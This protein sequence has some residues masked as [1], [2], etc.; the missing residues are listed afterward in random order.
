MWLELELEQVTLPVI[1]QWSSCTREHP[2]FKGAK[3]GTAQVSIGLLI[4]EVRKIV[5]FLEHAP[6]PSLHLI[7]NVLL[8]PH[9]KFLCKCDC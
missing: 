4:I 3:P 1:V 7:N 2:E 6:V 8:Y 9:N 5:T